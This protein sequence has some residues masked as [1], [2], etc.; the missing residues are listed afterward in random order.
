M[1]TLRYVLGREIVQV[2]A[3]TDAAP[4]RPL[5][6]LVALSL[7]FD[8]GSIGTI[9]TGRRTPDYPNNDVVVYGSLGRGGVEGSMDTNR[10][11]TLTV[12]T[13]AMTI[14]E[15]YEP[16]DSIELYTRQ[17]EAFNRAVSEG[18]EPAATGLDGLRVAEVTVA[19]VESARTGVQ[20]TIAP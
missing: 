17:V 11:G 6:E 12:R 9:M 3:I 14:E 15:S 20:V 7:R 4:E 8:D 16:P 13:D 18:T 2:A 5:E 10:A 1:D 19:M